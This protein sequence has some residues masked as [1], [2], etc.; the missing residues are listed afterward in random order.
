MKRVEGYYYPTPSQ[1]IDLVGSK[2]EAMIDTRDSLNMKL[3][4]YKTLRIEIG[5]RSLQT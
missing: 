5:M 2:T 3:M 4:M 1:L